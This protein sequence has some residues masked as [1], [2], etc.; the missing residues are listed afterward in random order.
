MFSTVSP[1]LYLM[2]LPSAFVFHATKFHPDKENP[3]DANVTVLSYTADDDCTVP[4]NSL[5]ALMGLL[6]L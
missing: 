5:V 1:S 3:F 6:P 2:P 4:I